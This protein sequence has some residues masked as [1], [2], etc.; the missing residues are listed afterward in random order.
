MLTD[1]GL[2]KR[3]PGEKLCKR[4]DRDGMDVAVL[5]INGREQIRESGDHTIK[6]VH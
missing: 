2:Q 6:V 4:G 3:K 1:T 5:P